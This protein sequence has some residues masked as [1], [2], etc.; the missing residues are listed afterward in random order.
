MKDSTGGFTKSVS[1][2]CPSRLRM[3]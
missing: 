2:A 1:A 3:T